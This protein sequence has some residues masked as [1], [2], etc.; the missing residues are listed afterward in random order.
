MSTT[1]SVFHCSTNSIHTYANTEKKAVTVKTPSSL[2]LRVSPLGIEITQMPTMMSR[3]KAAEPTMVDG[4]RPS[5]GGSPSVVTV[6]MTAS[7][8]SGA[9]EPSAISVRLAIVSF[10]TST[11]A[12]SVVPFG[13]LYVTTFS[14][15]VMTSMAAM[16]SSAMMA[17]PRKDQPSA[18]RYR[19]VRKPRLHESSARKKG[20]VRPSP[21]VTW[22]PGIAWSSSPSAGVDVRRALPSTC[23]SP[24]L[25]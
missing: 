18:T 4:P 20:S 15:E 10:H 21:H 7:R 3:L 19:I 17:M 14:L 24:S 22:S 23:S 9:D 25:S 11:R 13:S 6:S 5:L 1:F 12:T 16:N 2:I 8:I